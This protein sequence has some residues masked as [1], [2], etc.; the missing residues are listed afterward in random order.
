MEGIC[1]DIRIPPTMLS[2]SSEELSTLAGS[3]WAFS[4]G[5]FQMANQSL[6]HFNF[7]DLPCPPKSVMVISYSLILF[8]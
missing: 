1:N 5:R 8:Q 2:F 7:G 3:S 6:K 4:K